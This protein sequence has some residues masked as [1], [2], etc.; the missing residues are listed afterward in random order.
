VSLH[1]NK[2]GFQFK[3]CS[4]RLHKRESVLRS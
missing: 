3:R 1:K 4:L 2:Y